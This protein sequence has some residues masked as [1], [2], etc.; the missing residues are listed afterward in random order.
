MTRNNVL[1]ILLSSFDA[2][3]L[4]GVYQP[5]TNAGGIEQPIFYVKINNDSNYPF[6]LS[7]DGVNDHDYILASSIWYMNFQTNNLPNN[8]VAQLPRYT[9]LYAKVALA[10]IGKIYVSGFYSPQGV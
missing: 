3:T 1:P 10:G 6:F 2:S 4:S 5:I 8:H 9:Q 7:Y